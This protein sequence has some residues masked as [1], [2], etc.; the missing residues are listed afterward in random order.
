[1]LVLVGYAS[2]HGSTRG[3]AERIGTRL[4]DQGHQVEVKPLD[5]AGSPEGYGA[6]VLG[7]AVHNQ[8]WLEV[9]AGYV[10]DHQ[11]A[12]STRPVWVFSVGLVR[13]LGDRFEK[14][15]AEP[16]SIPAIREAIH[17]RDHRLLAG[18][19]EP[20]HFPRTG[21][22][23]Y[24]AMGGRYGDF[25]DWAEIDSWAAGIGRALVAGAASPGGSSTAENRGRGAAP[26]GE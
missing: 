13:V 5:R 22:L 2:E 16:K 6:V 1:M 25:R 24:R 23:I 3:I 21:R 20:D 14:R 4:A 19:V 11:A 7:S 17:P 15:G 10:H 18:A 26:A 12:L 8:A 9:A